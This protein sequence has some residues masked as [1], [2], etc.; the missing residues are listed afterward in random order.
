MS[1][2]ELK[3]SVIRIMAASL[4]SGQKYTAYAVFDGENLIVTQVE[5]IPWADVAWKSKLIAEI[6]DRKE[7]GFIVLVEE[8]TDHISQ[9]GTKY[10]LDE[11]W[12]GRTNFCDA[13]DWYFALQ[14]TG[15]L[16]FHKSCDQYKLYTGGEGQRVEKKTDDR[17]RTVY[18][19]EWS[20]FHSGYRAILL[21]VVAAMTEPV[22]RRYL[23]AM[24]GTHIEDEVVD[25]LRQFSAVTTG[26]DTEKA[27]W[28]EKYDR[29]RI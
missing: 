7:K 13:M 4:V 18:H 14:A 3:P 29:S 10:L 9:H 2:E 21:C 17:G 12:E 16:I 15:N 11:L 8:K 22:S 23:N 26:L 28:W 5:L 6:K 24:F 25:P 20:A 19:V 1:V 27:K